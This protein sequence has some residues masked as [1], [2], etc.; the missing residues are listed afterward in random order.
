MHITYACTKDKPKGKFIK[1]AVYIHTL[2]PLDPVDLTVP[3]KLFL[4]IFLN[5]N[6]FSQ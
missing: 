4:A 6:E 1:T 3:A 2:V 5:E